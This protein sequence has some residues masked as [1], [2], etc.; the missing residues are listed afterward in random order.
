MK[1]VTL[2]CLY[3]AQSVPMSFF[4]TVVPVIMRQENYPLEL[5]GMV[6]LIKLPWVIKFLWAPL[7]DKAG[8]SPRNYMK[9][10]FRA[11]LFYAVVVL[12]I[13]FLNLQ[14]NLLPVLLMMFIAV[15]ASATQDIATDAFAILVLSR[16]ERG[17]GNSMQSA[18]G[19]LG[20][21]L[22][23]GVL[24]IIFHYL[25]W[26]PLLAG[27]SLFVVAAL[28]P[29]LI[30]FYSYTEKYGY[31]PESRVGMTDLL[32]F[33]RRKGVTKRIVLLLMYY[34][35]VVGIMAMMKPW[36]IDLGLTIKQIGVISGLYGTAAGALFAFVAGVIIRR[37][38]RSWSVKAF[39]IA[40]SL[41]AL[42][43]YIL[44]LVGVT[45]TGIYILV[46]LIWSSYSMSTVIIY[47]I[48]MDEVRQGREGTDFTLQIVITQL[49]SLI[50]AVASGAFAEKFSYEHLF[51]ASFVLGVVNLIAVRYLYKEPPVS[52]RQTK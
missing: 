25:G 37:F 32:H 17:M 44:S 42:S 16:D 39:A 41:T 52:L 29:L 36:L 18:G 2:F 24:L 50:M 13:G 19:F 8:G 31:S 35:G 21:L 12:A 45:T 7:V 5:I 20:A 28:I 14:T 15:A 30:Y 4:T 34:G 48:S 27:L 33:F 23:S 38:G 3:I 46:A 47:T 6:Q 1:F 10:I 51:M 40:N 26:R 49:G 11:E 43:F 9:I 22:G